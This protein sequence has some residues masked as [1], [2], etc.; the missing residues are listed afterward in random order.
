LS[1]AQLLEQFARQRDLQAFEVLFRRHAP[2][3][4]KV[5]RRLLGCHHSAED[6]FQA[7]FLVLARRA[8][9]IRKPSSLAC[10][11]HG[12]AYR[13]ARRGRADAGP[14]PVREE[15]FPSAATTD[16]AQ[17]A[18]WRELG[19]IIAEE[20]SSL[21]EKYR[22]PILLCYWQGMTIEEAARHL[23]WPAGTV[24]TRLAKARQL[25]HDR[26]VGR[27]V[28]LS[29]GAAV[30]L[31]ATTPVEAAV[32]A[33]QLTATITAASRFAAGLMP[34]T[35]ST[36]ATVL[37]E[38]VLKRMV[39]AKL[40]ALTALVLAVAAVSG[41]G[42]LAYQALLAEAPQAQTHNGASAA[43]LKDQP[44]LP[45]KNQARLD[46][47]GDPLPQ[48]AI[49]RLGTL[50]F[51][52]VRGCLAFA[53]NGK[54]LAAAGGSAGSQAI[55]WDP[56]TG[57]QVRQIGRQ[58]TLTHLAFS[59]DGKRLA[60]SD[61]SARAQVFDVDSGKELFTIEGFAA[62]FSGDGEVLV[63]ADRYGTAP[64]IHVWDAATGQ[65]LRRWRAGEG[66]EE[67]ALA[68]DS[69]T[70][71]LIDRKEPDLVRLRDL[72][73][74]A[75]VCSIRL[76]SGGRHF[77]ALASDGKAL[78]TVSSTGVQ[79]WDARS[80]KQVR[81]WGQR[82][83]S[84]P[85]FSPDGKR[86]AW[87][88][89]DGIARLWV[90]ECDGATPRAVGEPVNHFEPPCFSPDG[91]MLAVITDA[92]AVQLREVA[93][94]KDVLPLEAHDSPLMGLAFTPDG[95]H[96][97]SH[98]RTG[99]FA[100]E[101]L[102]GR[103]VRRLPAPLP[104]RERIVTVLPDS[105]LLTEDP[106][107]DPREGLFRV[108]DALTGREALRFEGRPDVGPPSVA[109]APG[110]RFAALRGRAGETC[111]VDL[112]AGRLV[113][114]DDPKGAAG[115]LWL[116]ADGDILVFWHQSL[117]GEPREVHVRCQTTSRRLVLRGLPDDQ[118]FGWWLTYRPCVSPDGRWLVVPTEDGRLRRW[119][120]ADG[121]EVPSLPEPQRTVWYLYW[122]PDGRLVG[123]S[124]TA[125][126]PG[127]KDREARR[128]LRF[129]D[130]ATGRRLTYLEMPDVPDCVLFSHDS[131]TLFTADHAGLIRLAEVA[132]GKERKRLSGH[133]EGGVGA[134]AISAEGRI[135]SS[136]GYDSQVLVWD[137]TGRMPDGQWRPERQR[138][139]ELG[140]AWE[141]L[142]GPDARA[143][144]TALW[145]LAADPEA[146]T[147]LFGRELR[148]VVR[149]DESRLASLMADLDSQ[150]FAAREKSTQELGKLGELAEGRLRKTLAARPTL[151]VRRR[152]EGLLQKLQGPITSPERLRALRALEV[153]EQIGT[154]E[155][156]QVLEKIARGAPGARLT[157]EAKVS[158]ERLARR[159][160]STR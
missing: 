124:G 50:R 66:V 72:T 101:A 71:A 159:L 78:A 150:D 8:D 107:E 89:Y 148:P 29:V 45:E 2:L 61:N 144:Y 51:R 12:V 91:R 80:G 63:T 56:A 39:A 127:V 1:D 75:T 117:P 92:Q 138:P 73:T 140:G 87:T 54:L 121:K 103:L 82:S 158:L 118:R 31:V 123:T 42:V 34:S 5:C 153:L 27:G 55:L 98:A 37:A 69:L 58:T 122:S 86:L 119:D 13:I 20:V 100:W 154:R 156:K 77:L 113:Y 4:W 28:T 112:L 74:G 115:G 38:S 99:I 135:L 142:A 70:L 48:G 41:T 22:A 16:P 136:G 62:V 68:A 40:K 60:C 81:G 15:R 18:A 152:V 6:A 104:G 25:L 88:G 33:M 90:V 102:T 17:Q 146:T 132:T 53:P 19:W 47:Y 110:G 96:L 108:R 85:V 155:A 23:G 137:L 139:E 133:L 109:P 95:R 76:P 64:Q 43:E 26:L 106:T 129:W 111:V 105:R 149:V 94:G 24:K 49:A 125:A 7:T 151:E 32:P 59:P 93:T 52:G 116:S 128:D 84:A 44:K 143:A 14:V 67:M 126:E 21:A 3:V 97:V 131:R 114:R 57:R 79:L 9:S 46:R 157:E 147:A 10:W 83:D 35:T 134:L 145:Q 36:A 130:V 141:I 11:L 65:R 160:G 30:A 120:L